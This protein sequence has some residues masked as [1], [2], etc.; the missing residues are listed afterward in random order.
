MKLIEACSEATPLAALNGSKAKSFA[1][2]DQR[3]GCRGTVSGWTGE[4]RVFGTKNGIRLQRILFPDLVPE[5][6]QI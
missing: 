6:S 2:V 1:A 3:A 4:Q 5:F